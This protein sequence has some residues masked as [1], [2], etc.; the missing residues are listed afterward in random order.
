MSKCCRVDLQPRGFLLILAILLPV[1]VLF[2]YSD[3]G[4]PLFT[5]TFLADYDVDAL[6]RSW[7]V[8]GGLEVDLG[9]SLVNATGGHFEG[10]LAISAR[11]CYRPGDAE[12][13]ILGML[14]SEDIPK[15][16][17]CESLLG[18]MMVRFGDERSKIEDSTAWQQDEDVWEEAFDFTVRIFGALAGVVADRT[19]IKSGGGFLEDMTDIFDMYMLTFADVEQMHEG[20]PLLAEAHGVDGLKHSFHTWVSIF[21]CLGYVMMVLR[22]LAIIGVSPITGFVERHI[23]SVFREDE[24]SALVASLLSMIFIEAPFLGL[25]WIAWYAYGLPVSIFAIKNVFGIYSDLHE[26]GL[27]NG[28]D[29]NGRP[30]GLRLCCARRKDVAL[31]CTSLGD[32]VSAVAV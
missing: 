8:G 15:Q 23:S 25:R 18:T 5:D 13:K 24:L 11:D 21:L 2:F 17:Y 19:L 27:I 9:R 14:R 22:A 30:R 12:F 6:M 7:P 4:R 10:L 29:A 20:R 31:G 28:F 32:G 1:N 3:I 16:A 26:L